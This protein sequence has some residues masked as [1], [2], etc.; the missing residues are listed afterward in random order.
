MRE[1]VKELLKMSRYYQLNYNP[2]QQ[3]DILDNFKK[4]FNI[5]LY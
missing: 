4:Y 1:E 3:S 5:T 2:Y